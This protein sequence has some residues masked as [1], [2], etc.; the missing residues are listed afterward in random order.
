MRNLLKINNPD[1]QFFSF[2]VSKKKSTFSPQCTERWVNRDRN[3]NQTIAT[4][5]ISVIRLN[6]VKMYTMQHAEMERMIGHVDFY[7][8]VW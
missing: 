5:L 6:L 1:D 2:T 8:H 7:S 4:D 3:E